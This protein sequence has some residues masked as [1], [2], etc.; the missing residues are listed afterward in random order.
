MGRG[1]YFFCQPGDSPDYAMLCARELEKFHLRTGKHTGD[2]GILSCVVECEDDQFFDLY[3][4]N[5][6]ESFHRMR[7]L[8]LNKALESNPDYQY[9]NAAVAD[10]QVFNVIRELRSVAVIQCPQFFGML[11]EEQKFKFPKGTHQF[12][13]TYVPNVIM[14]CVDTDIAKVTNIQLA[15]R[16]SLE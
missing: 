2:Y 11:A 12:P 5:G 15:E 8:M 13:K 1:V 6:M 16:G 7:Y 4:P 3:D 14:I 9:P 10:T